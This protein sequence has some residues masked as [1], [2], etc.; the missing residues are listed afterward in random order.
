MHSEYDWL[1]FYKWD[2]DSQYPCVDGTDSCLTDDDKYLSSN[3]PCDGIQ[4]EGLR[5]GGSVCTATCPYAKHA[6]E[7]AKAEGAT[8]P[9]AQSSI[10]FP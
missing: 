6:G 1:R 2:G 5:N 4:Q 3:N 9:P 10:L 8:E 7:A